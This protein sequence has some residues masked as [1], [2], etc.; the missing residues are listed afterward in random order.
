[1]RTEPKAPE[2]FNIDTISIVA[3]LVDRFTLLNF[4]FFNS[5]YLSK[6]MTS[7]FMTEALLAT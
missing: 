5:T 7:R 1:M 2:Q 4:F 3:P 6:L